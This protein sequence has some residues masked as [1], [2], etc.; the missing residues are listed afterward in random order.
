MSV[1]IIGYLSYGYPN[2]EESIERAD[3][4]IEAGCDFLEVDFPT[5]NA[6]LDSDFIGS[7]MK[8]AMEACNDFDKYFDGIKTLKEKYPDTPIILLAYEHTIKAI[9]MEK[10]IT[11]C[12]ELE[13]YDLIMVGLENED[14][15]NQLIAEGIKISCWVPFDLP[16]ENVESALHSNGFVYLQSKSS[17]EE[18]EG[19]ETLDKCVAYLRER[20][21]KNPIYCGVGVSTRED[22]IRIEE[23]GADAAFIGSALLKQETN[24]DIIHY[25]K[26]LKG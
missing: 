26:S 17:G 24:Q 11:R 13:T 15:K 19:Y 2:I 6:F 22:I 14:V 20:G 5:D 10:F 21:L 23:A 4:Y 3:I 18:K 9:G 25:I 1:K 12:K 8:S 7:R 16:K